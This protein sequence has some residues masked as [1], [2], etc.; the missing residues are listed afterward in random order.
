MSRSVVEKNAERNEDS[1]TIEEWY[2]SQHRDNFP[3]DPDIC[4]STV[5][6]FPYDRTF[7][8]ELPSINKIEPDTPRKKVQAH[9]KLPA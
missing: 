3:I 9:F 7:S 4:V 2:K 6:Y 8:D 5:L 1:E